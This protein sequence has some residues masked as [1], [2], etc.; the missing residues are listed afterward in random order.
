MSRIISVILSVVMLVTMYAFMV[1]ADDSDASESGEETSSTEVQH[2]LFTVAIDPAT[3]TPVPAAGSRDYYIDQWNNCSSNYERYNMPA[4]AKASIVGLSMDEFD[5]MARVI[6]AEGDIKGDD[7]TDKVLV[8]CV[9][10]NRL[11]CKKYPNTIT[12]VVTQRGQFEVIENGLASRRRRTKDSE[13]AIMV[14]YMLVKNNDISPHLMAFNC[15]NYNKGYAPYFYNGGNYFSCGA[16]TCSRCK[17]LEPG[18]KVSGYPRWTTTFKRPTD[19]GGGMTIE[20]EIAG[21]TR[22]FY[23]NHID[24]SSITPTPTPVPSYD[25]NNLIIT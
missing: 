6:Q 12:R 4:K 11:Y 24:Q 8:A 13:W 15:I 2:R 1:R 17:K 7:L 23:T 14:A 22:G 10:W 16:C 3:P 19:T 5:L 18:F 20:E 9:I 25:Y 21:F